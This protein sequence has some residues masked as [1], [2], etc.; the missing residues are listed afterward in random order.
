MGDRTMY[1]LPIRVVE[2]NSDQLFN[3]NYS[4]FEFWGFGCLYFLHWAI[5]RTLIINHIS[6]IVAIFRCYTHLACS[7]E[8]IIDKF[9]FVI[10]SVGH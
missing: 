7:C 10:V 2:S 1:S 8:F 4:F 5:P 3:S 9:A 6:F